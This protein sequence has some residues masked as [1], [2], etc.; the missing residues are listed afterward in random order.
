MDFI[1]GTCENPPLT[2]TDYRSSFSRLGSEDTGRGRLLRYYVKDSMGAF[3]HS[4]R[5]GGW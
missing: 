4:P 5:G 2:Y 3:H 1:L